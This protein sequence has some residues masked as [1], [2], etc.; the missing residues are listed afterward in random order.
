MSGAVKRLHQLAWQPGAWLESSWWAHLSLAEWESIYD[1]HASCRRAIDATLVARRGF[2]KQPLPGTLSVRQNALMALEPRLSE[3]ATALGLIALDCPEYLLLRDYREALSIHLGDRA[4]EQLFIL[5][6]GWKA[7]PTI[8]DHSRLG[9]VALQTG[10]QWL[11][12]EAGNCAVSHG[13]LGLLPHS[14]NAVQDSLLNQAASA[15]EWLIKLGR[16]L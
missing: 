16:F 12:R 3:L 1:D 9:E 6:P 7:R 14:G 11:S 5:H 4:C 10:T 2:P 15:P 13:L 8:E